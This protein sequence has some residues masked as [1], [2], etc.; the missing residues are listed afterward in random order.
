MRRR[1]ILMAGFGVVGSLRF[2]GL[3]AFAETE[4]HTLPE[5][6][7]VETRIEAEAEEISLEDLRSGRY[8]NLGEVATE[9]PGV[10]GVKRAH[11][12]VE[13]V[14]RGLG[15]ERVQT[16]VDGLPV[17]GACPGRMD[18]PAMILQPETVQEAHAV[19]GVPSVT[20]GPA[21]TGGRVTERTV[22]EQLLYEI[23]DPRAYVTPDC[24][25][26]FTTIELSDE[27][28]DRVGI[29]GVRGRAAPGT[30]KVSCVYSAG[31]K[32]T[33]Q[34]TYCWPEAAAKARAAGELLRRR[35][36]AVVGDAFEEFLVECVGAGA[37][38]GTAP[39]R[40][41]DEVVLRVSARS[42]ERGPCDRL[43]RELVGLILT[44]PPGATG[45]A[46][47][48]PRPS[49]VVGIWSGLVPREE[50][51]PRVEVLE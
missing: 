12:A 26:D 23:G 46:A 20:L 50:V 2:F 13:P 4:T 33:G 35:T 28:D 32:V 36:E 24:I 10:N 15:W 43:G 49:E 47:G 1:W 40:E 41:P 11:S 42:P 45:Y 44:G 51:E 38:F 3:R 21:G 22:K 30:L 37:C 19:K 34:I 14:I 8:T 25:A 31:W 48:R 9:I 5:T 6:R 27:G 29:S 39:E 7:V 16:Q 17:Y 18:P